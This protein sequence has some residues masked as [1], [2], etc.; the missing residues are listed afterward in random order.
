MSIGVFLGF[1]LRGGDRAAPV[2]G[3]WENRT[4]LWVLA[5]LW[6]VVYVRAMILNA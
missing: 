5:S 2:R 3:R 6:S 4:G 1:S